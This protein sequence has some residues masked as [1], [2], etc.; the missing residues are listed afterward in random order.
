MERY[1]LKLVIKKAINEIMDDLKA[2]VQDAVRE[3]L[4]EVE[5][6][7]TKQSVSTLG[8]GVTQDYM[9]RVY[10]M[11]RCVPWPPCSLAANLL[12]AEIFTGMEISDKSVNGMLKA[13]SEKL[14]E[15][16]EQLVIKIYREVLAQ[17]L[18]PAIHDLWKEAGEPHVK[19]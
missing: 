9:E 5:V 19:G 16:E 4:E 6:M 15:P 7:P 8:P 13:V 18:A 10:T 11:L 14:G 17:L 1:E 2:A 3:A 12:G